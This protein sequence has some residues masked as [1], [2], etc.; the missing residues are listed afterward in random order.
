MLESLGIA[1]SAVVP[2]LIYLGL[3]YLIVSTRMADR[4]F[5]NTLNRVNFRVMFPV[6]MFHHIYH[7]SVG[8]MPSLKLILAA[9]LSILALIAA[10]LLA[11][12]RL[13]RENPR[14]G[15]VIQGIFRSNYVLY[16][17]PLTQFVFGTEN[18]GIAGIMVM[19]V[20]MVFNTSAVVVLELFNGEGRVNV[21][22]LPMKL[23]KNPLLQGCFLGLAFFLLGWKL[24]SFLESPVSSLANMTTPL[25]L[26]TLGGVLQFSA[27]KKNRRILLPALGAKLILVPL[28]LL[29][30]GWEIGLRKVELFLY[31]MIFATPTATSSYPMAVNMGGDGELAGQM[32]FLST[33]VSLATVFLF[34]FALSATG[35]LTA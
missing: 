14:R 23:I 33:V 22:A 27:I 30:V 5:M 19:I 20:V 18:T 31:L 6:L 10:L 21:R 17:I 3:G 7:A 4:D 26:I 25:A 13:I 29:A 28:L 12:P 2:F 15:V 1:F 11:V 24:P 35:M 9:V 16:G 32:V 34:I 8:N